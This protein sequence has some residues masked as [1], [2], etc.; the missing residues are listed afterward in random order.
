[1]SPLCRPT[2]P[3]EVGS[4]AGDEAGLAIVRQIALDDVCDDDLVTV[5]NEFRGKMAA[6]E[7]VTAEDDV[8]HWASSLVW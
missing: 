4:V 3:T 8:S 5:R 6:D 1:M 7:S 2:W